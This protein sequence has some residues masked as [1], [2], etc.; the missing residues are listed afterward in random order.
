MIK[1]YLKIALRN[2]MRNKLYAS[3]NILGLAIGMACCV[4]IFSAMHQ[5]WSFD[6]FH[7]NR[8][9]IFRV[10]TREITKEGE[11][12]F[13]VKQPRELAAA[14]EETFPEIVHTTRFSNSTVIVGR[15]DKLFRERIALIDP[16]YLQ[17]FTFPLLAGDANSAL[18]NLHSVVISERVAR[19]YFDETEN[20]A[21]VI[22]LIAAY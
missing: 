18:D 16:G 13:T 22:G 2:L 6:R 12:A 20:Y 9:V 4:L 7:E 1:N 17:M 3:I 19:K 11:V 15:E 10:L 14:L 5:Q 8:D 21:H